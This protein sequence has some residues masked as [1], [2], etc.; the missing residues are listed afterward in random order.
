[1]S[2]EIL[3]RITKGCFLFSI[4]SL[5]TSL[6][7]IILIV[8]QKKLRSIT[9]TFLMFIFASEIFQSIG[10]LLIDFTE[11]NEDN[12]KAKNIAA[13]CLISVSDIFTNLL[14]VFFTYCSIKLI[15]ET[16]KL[17]KRYVPRFIIISLAFSLVYMIIYLILGLKEENGVDIR[18]REFYSKEDIEEE[19]FPKIFF[20]LSSIHIF[21]LI[22]FSVVSL[23]NTCIVL[24]FLGQKQKMDKANFKSIA[25]LIK[26]L[27]R[28]PIICILYWIFL[29]PR[30]IFVS[31]TSKQNIL[32]DTI[33]LISEALLRLRGF[34]I[35]LNTFRSSKI[36]LII[37][38][39]IQIDIKHNCLLNLK[40]CGKRNI[41]RNKSNTKNEAEKPLIVE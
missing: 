24:S 31:T 6:L 28:Y 29:I 10:N 40:L 14:L 21:F 5:I 19:K 30:I 4:L 34:L 3:E 11:K 7:I 23:R 2:Q 16:N 32:R 22:V 17:I 33:Y 8:F 41:P 13:L 15:K 37:Y 36:Q 1:M 27:R 12:F 38:K 25:R 9:Y 26:I 18:F 35:F 20:V 39:I